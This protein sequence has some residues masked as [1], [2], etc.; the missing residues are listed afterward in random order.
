MNIQSIGIQAKNTDDIISALKQGFPADSF[1][2]LR[3][4]LKVSDN[5]LSKI[6]QIPKRTLTRRRQDGRLR[7]D[8]SERV[9]RIARVYDKAL[10]VLENEEAAENWLKKP[11]RG[12]GY[13]I[14]LEYADTELGAQ[15]V[16]NLLGRIEHGVFPG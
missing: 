13:K 16:I 10:D 11:A 14:P 2:K 5:L 15:E 6:V 4:R 12:L 3:D 8:E 7:T 9:L 1:D